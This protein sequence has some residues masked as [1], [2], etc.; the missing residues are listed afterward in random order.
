MQEEK[1]AA[2]RSRASVRIVKPDDASKL[3]ASYLEWAG[4]LSYQTELERTSSLEQ[5]AVNLLSSVSIISV[6]LLTIAPL[7]FNHYSETGDETLGLPCRLLAL[8]YGSTVF[9]LG[10][11]FL[12]ALLSQ[13]RLK[14]QVPASPKQ[15]VAYVNSEIEAG[16]PI[17][18]AIDLAQ[19]KC[20]TMQPHFESLYKKNEFVRKMLR[21]A[22]VALVIAL[23]ISLFLLCF[24]LICD[25]LSPAFWR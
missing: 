25:H 3:S 6:A 19:M 10:I 24:F 21:G 11:A 20:Q 5:L 9:L 17:S 2:N 8:G 23:G 18:S 14:Q 7:L 22:M 1:P 12:L 16:R 15:L 4:N 13:M